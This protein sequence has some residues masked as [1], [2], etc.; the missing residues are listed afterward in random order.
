MNQSQQ[1]NET[2]AYNLTDGFCPHGIKFEKSTTNERPASVN[3]VPP[4]VS[5]TPMPRR[6]KCG[7]CRTL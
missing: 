4:M 2:C 5:P 7:Y 6:G 1:C 3:P